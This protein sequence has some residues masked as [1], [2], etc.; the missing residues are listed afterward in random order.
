MMTTL[1]TIK[2]TSGNGL[3]DYVDDIVNVN[4]MVNNLYTIGLWIKLKHKKRNS[5]FYKFTSKYRDT[6]SPCT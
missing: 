5:K 4:D 6:L 2:E 1:N 3:L